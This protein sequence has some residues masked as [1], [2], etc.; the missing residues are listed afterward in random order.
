M[1]Y[2]ISLLIA[3]VLVAIAVVIFALVLQPKTTATGASSGAKQTVILHN[4]SGGSGQ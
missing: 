2:V 4:G 1:R 3:A